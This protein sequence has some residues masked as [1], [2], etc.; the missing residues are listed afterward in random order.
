M[1]RWITTANAVLNDTRI[2]ITSYC[3]DGQG[4]YK[5]FGKEKNMSKK[6]ISGEFIPEAALPCAESFQRLGEQFIDNI[7]N[8]PEESTQNFNIDISNVASSATN[9]ALALEIYL[10]TLLSQL[11]KHIPKIHDLWKLYTALPQK[12][13]K[14]IEDKYDK[15][16]HSLPKNKPDSI[17]IAKGPHNTPEWERNKLPGIAELL[18]RSADV[19]LSWRY[20][21]VYEPKENG[22]E[23]HQF[24]YRLLVLAC[25]A[26]K[27]CILNHDKGNAS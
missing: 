10:K 9:L 22:Y 3:N 8:I 20:I 19:F 15:A 24:E 17:T 6:F 18:K 25:K 12:I 13:K 2:A 1:S 11:G 16:L 7:G 23:P 5:R 4:I 14:E 21:F 26:I 27:A